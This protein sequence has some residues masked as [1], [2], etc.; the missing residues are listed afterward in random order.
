[1]HTLQSI[2]AATDLSTA[3]GRAARR[4]GWLA[5][6][7]GAEL[8]L[9]HVQEQDALLALRNVLDAGRDLAAAATEQAR[10]ELHALAHDVQRRSGARARAELQAGNVLDTLNAAAGEADLLVVGARGANPVREAVLGTT[11][12]RLV[13][14]ARLPSVVVR[15]EPAGAYARVLAAVDFSP[16]S[17]DAL[18]F[19]RRLA[20]QAEFH[21]LHCYD[22][23]FEGKLRTAGATDD[24]VRRRR[25]EEAARAQ[26]QLDA[27]LQR[28]PG[29]RIGG[30]LRRGDPRVELLRSAGEL[31]ADL[32]VVGKQGSSRLGE[33]LFG[34]VAGWVLAQATCDVLVVPGPP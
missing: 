11:A 24:Q 6:T 5:A 4:A 2:L 3:G 23:P 14:L 19:A 15:G 8:T 26:Q 7:H 30:M 20:P 31:Q 16:M 22:V 25:D 33:A 10:M 17:E 27:L 18:Q 9:L 32:L 1:M 12:E 34:S 13:R 21:L 29:D 28:Q